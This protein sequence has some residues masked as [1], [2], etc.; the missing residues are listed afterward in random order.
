MHMVD[1]A[2]RAW[3]GS[4][5]Q[6]LHASDAAAP[7]SSLAVLKL[8]GTGQEQGAAHHAYAMAIRSGCLTAAEATRQFRLTQVSDPPYP[9]TYWHRY[10]DLEAASLVGQIQWGLDYLRKHWG[11][12]LEAG[13]TTLWET[14]DPSWLG[15]DPH[16]MSI[17]TSEKPTFGGYRTAHC[18]GG[19]AGPAAWLPQAV[20]GVTPTRDG[21]ATIRFSPALGDLDWAEGT[22]P[23]PRGPIH[24]SLR[25]RPNALPLAELTL[26]T[27]IE[28]QI[29]D[30][31]Q[32]GWEI[33]TDRASPSDRESPC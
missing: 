12:V 25:R 27:G 28:I 17:V 3:L 9:M 29:S 24:V 22:L 15:P 8:P 23:S 30:E 21:F 5:L 20:L 31:T 2:R 14:F 18:H 13:M 10:A 11:S 16:G 4:D 7:S 1:A 32:R 26:P 33:C 19:A 6:A